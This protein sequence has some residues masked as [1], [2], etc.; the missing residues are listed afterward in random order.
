MRSSSVLAFCAPAQRSGGVRKCRGCARG[1]TTTAAS[2]A[3]LVSR[4]CSPDESGLPDSP[5]SVPARASGASPRV[6]SVR[7][8]GRGGGRAGGSEQRLAAARARRVAAAG[9]AAGLESA[10]A[11]RRHFAGLARSM[12]GTTFHGR[13]QRW[14]VKLPRYGLRAGREPLN[15]RYFRIPTALRCRTHNLRSRGSDLPLGTGPGSAYCDIVSA[16][17]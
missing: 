4:G 6:R 14:T 17:P 15:E 5:R 7:R 13:N 1:P 9:C 12:E 10:G 2:A 8:R 3:A 16:V 11:S